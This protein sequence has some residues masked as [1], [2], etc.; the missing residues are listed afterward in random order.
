MSWEALTTTQT[1]VT[2]DVQFNV[3]AFVA[4][5]FSVKY[6]VLMPENLTRGTVTLMRIR[7]SFTSYFQVIGL[8]SAGASAEAF[9]AASIQLVPLANGVIQDTAV[10]NTL[11]SADS[12]SNRIL[13]RRNY[14]P[15]M[16]ENGGTINAI[17]YMH[18]KQT[19]EVDVKVKRRFDRSRYALIWV[20]AI[21]TSATLET[22]IGVDAR[23]LFLAADGL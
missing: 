10:L 17:R 21:S 2:A 6:L 19:T 3:L 4:G 22:L 14:S 13:W 18:Q 9:I 5:I 16:I 15:V 7:G 8:A 20:I 1:P 11:N 12:E 23:A